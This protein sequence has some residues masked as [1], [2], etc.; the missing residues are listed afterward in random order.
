MFKMLYGEQQDEYSR[1]FRDVGLPHY[2]ASA[3]Y[4]YVEHGIDGGG[5]L[6]AVLCNNLEESFRRADINNKQCL[7]EWCKVLT[8]CVPAACWGSSR[9]VRD[10]IE[11]KRTERCRED[12]VNKVET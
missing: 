1:T 9:N 6:K 10:W 3:L 11:K 7:K 4:N 8:W 2:M 12:V 5:F